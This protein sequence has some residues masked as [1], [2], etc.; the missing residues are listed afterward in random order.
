MSNKIWKD[1]NMLSIYREAQPINTI[2]TE[3]ILENDLFRF[4][5]ID[6][7]KI[8]ADGTGIVYNNEFRVE[9]KGDA[10]LNGINIYFSSYRKEISIGIYTGTPS[11]PQ[12]F[13][14]YVKSPKKFIKAFEEA[15]DFAKEISEKIGWKFVE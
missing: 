7:K 8:N 2:V 6:G 4:Y 3:D 15:V 12:A 13:L 11:R 14:M 5:R 10:K 1:N 9:P